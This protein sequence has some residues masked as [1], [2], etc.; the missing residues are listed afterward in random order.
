[1]DTNPSEHVDIYIDTWRHGPRCTLVCVRER[2]FF[3]SCF[4][5]KDVW[6]SKQKKFH[7]QPQAY[8]QIKTPKYTDGGTLVMTCGSCTPSIKK[9][10][11]PRPVAVPEPGPVPASEPEPEPE[12]A[13]AHAPASGPVLPLAHAPAPAPRRGGGGGGGRCSSK[14][15]VCWPLHCPHC[16]DVRTDVIGVSPH[17][18]PWRS[19][20]E[21][22]RNW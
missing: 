2:R 11:T 20:P 7:P 6:S 9:Y 14:L 13:L 4:E 3:C 15:T 1:M 18:I 5:L 12:P 17:T 19:P 16:A 22:E 10:R 8:R 21:P